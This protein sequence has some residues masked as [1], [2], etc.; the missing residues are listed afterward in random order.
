[1]SDRRML[2]LPAELVKKIDENRGD[3]SQADFIEMLID[4]HFKEKELDGKYATKQEVQ[5]FQEDIKRLLK[6]FLDFFVSYGLEMG[7]SV[8]GG[9]GDDL[10]EL[11]AKLQGMQ[12]GGG[13]DNEKGGKATIKWK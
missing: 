7:K 13:S 8:P 1:M 12:K 2:I 5:A 11:A 9:P 3:V 10:E 6:S 4:S